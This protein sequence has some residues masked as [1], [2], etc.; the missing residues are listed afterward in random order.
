MTIES[1]D[2]ITGLR[3]IGA[4]VADCLAYMRS[5]A[6]PGMTTRELDA[7]GAA[8]LTDRDA[9]SAPQ[10]TYGFPGCTCISVG[11]AVAHGIPNETRLS[12]GDIVN[13]DVSAELGG[14]FADTGGSFV[15]PGGPGQ[16]ELL[17]LC[18][19]T[20]DARDAGVAAVRDGAPFTDVGRAVEKVARA[21]RYRVLE[22]LAS[23]GVGRAL[24]ES[25]GHIPNHF[26][27]RERRV[28]RKGMVITIEPFLT[29]GPRNVTQS[30]DGWTLLLPSKHRGAQF[31]HTLVVTEGAPLIVTV[32]TG[33][34]A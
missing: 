34:V 17:R 33:A 31:E 10:L 16:R 6:E 14:Y 30:D 2:D 29:T 28:F 1:E 8:F 18:E 22:D 9:R 7:L 24:H 21:H 32:P 19:A 23:H 13:V 12:R 25:P 5:M 15:L 27:P 3:R 4:I 20:R 11:A 26:D